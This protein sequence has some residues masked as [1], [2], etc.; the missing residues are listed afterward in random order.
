[1]GLVTAAHSRRTRLLALLV[2]AALLCAPLAGFAAPRS[3]HSCC[4]A[5]DAPC[6]DSQPCTSLAPKSCCDVAPAAAWPGAVQRECG[7]MP[8]ILMR[9]LAPLASPPALVAIP[10]PTRADVAPPLRLSM[11]LRN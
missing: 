9:A 10:A 6:A 7:Q 8:Q 3:D 1:M 2:L 5:M 4:P 11:V